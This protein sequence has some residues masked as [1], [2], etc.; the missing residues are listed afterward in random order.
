MRWHT[1]R[2][3]DDPEYIRH[4]SDGESWQLFDKEYP[5]F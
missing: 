4:P 1:L 5:D 2:N 3:V